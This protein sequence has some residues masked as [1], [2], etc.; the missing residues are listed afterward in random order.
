MLLGDPVEAAE[1][2]GQDL[3]DVLFDEAEDV[4]VIPEVQRPLCDLGPHTEQCFRLG[5]IQRRLIPLL[6]G[7]LTKYGILI[8]LEH[9]R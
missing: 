7:Y 5:H 9:K 6:I 8:T 4:L 2:D 1:H 3:V